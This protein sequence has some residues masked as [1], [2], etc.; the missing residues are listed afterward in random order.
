[1][2]TRTRPAALQAADGAEAGETPETSGAEEAPASANGKG[3]ALSLP[4]LPRLPRV[5]I[6][7]D[8]PIPALERM[9]RRDEAEIILLAGNVALVALEV[10]E[11]PVAILT[12]AVHA[13]HR[14]RFKGL[15]A[16][17][18]VVEEAE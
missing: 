8:N 6:Q 18:E 3:R 9:L 1:M 15:E 2:A 13:I 4:G 14:T 7:L 11:W 12:L 5:K 10:I 16:L 17:A